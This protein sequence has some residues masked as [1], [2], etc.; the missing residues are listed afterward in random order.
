MNALPLAFRCGS[1]P[2]P[3]VSSCVT[4]SAPNWKM[5]LSTDMV[6]N[7]S[8]WPHIKFL[9]IYNYGPGLIKLA[10]KRQQQGL[11]MGLEKAPLAS[12]MTADV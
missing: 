5:S 12:T 4:F 9:N 3:C 2:E 8:I 1:D 7:E 11:H 10:G 6:Y